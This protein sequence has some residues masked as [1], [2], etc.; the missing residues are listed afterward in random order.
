[1]YVFQT[2]VAAD[3]HENIFVLRVPPR[4]HNLSKH[5]ATLLFDTVAHF[6]VGDLVV[7][8][9][10]AETL[11]GHEYILAATV[12]GSIRAFLPLISRKTLTLVQ[13]LQSSLR[14]T[15]KEL[16]DRD[17]LAFRSYHLPCQG[18]IDGDLCNRFLS[19]PSSTQSTISQSLGS[20]SDTVQRTLEELRS[21]IV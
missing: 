8:L 14:V 21:R 9:K 19:L 3:K 20:N 16:L 18:V 4:G 1:M 13:K 12:T 11:S 7:S 17:H 5:G 15:I 6:F 10:L 2:V